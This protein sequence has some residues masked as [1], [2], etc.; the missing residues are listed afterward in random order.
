MSF[1]RQIEKW[2]LVITAQEEYQGGERVFWP[3]PGPFIP[4]FFLNSGFVSQTKNLKV[5]IPL[6]SNDEL[7]DEKIQLIQE[8]SKYLKCIDLMNNTK[9]L[10]GIRHARKQADSVNWV[11][12]DDLFYYYEQESSDKTHPFLTFNLTDSLDD[13]NFKFFAAWMRFVVYKGDI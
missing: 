6:G 1:N 10:R 3:D 13:D 8:F 2:G 12:L 9:A 7:I 11:F 4:D 5:H